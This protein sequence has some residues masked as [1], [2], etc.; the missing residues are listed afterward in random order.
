MRILRRATALRLQSLIEAIVLGMV[1]GGGPVFVVVAIGLVSCCAYVYFNVFIPK[2]FPADSLTTWG[3]IAKYTHLLFTVYLLVLIAFQYGMAVLVGP[4]K[5]DKDTESGHSDVPHDSLAHSEHTHDTS[6][7]ISE[8]HESHRKVC[9]KCLIPKP[10]R[11]HHCRVCKRCVLRMDH[12]CPWI[13]NCVGYHNHRYFYLFLVYLTIACVYFVICMAPIMLR[14]YWYHQEVD[15]GSGG[16]K[17][18]AAFGFLLAFAL[19]FGVGSLMSWHTYLVLTGQTTIEYYDNQSK[20]KLAR[21]R[22][23]VYINEFD[24]GTIRNARIF[25]GIGKKFPWYTILLPIAVP[26]LGDGRTY[27]TSHAFLSSQERR[28]RWVDDGLELV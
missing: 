10:E 21:L 26:P 23:D 13:S 5:T 2:T 3:A 25:F 7:G 8:P 15:W 17:H 16:M 28:P 4:G 18:L 12:H 27:L 9:K 24:L 20:R 22:G 14:Y 11:A 1:S 19:I 6:V